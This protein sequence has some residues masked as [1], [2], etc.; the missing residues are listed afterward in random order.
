MFVSIAWSIVYCGAPGG[1]RSA[2]YATI[3]LD[4]QYFKGFC[5]LPVSRHFLVVWWSLQIFT[6]SMSLGPQEAFIDHR[7]SYVGATAFHLT[8][9][10]Q[11]AYRAPCV[12][13]HTLKWFCTL[14]RVSST[15][16]TEDSL[17][18]SMHCSSV[19]V[20]RGLWS[21]S[22]CCWS[23]AR[24]SWPFSGFSPLGLPLEIGWSMQFVDLHMHPPPKNV[25]NQLD[26]TSNDKQ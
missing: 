24:A 22:H 26:M 6:L 15:H 7:K 2:F 12:A 16:P 5:H 23:V 8:K 20:V 3:D 25:I 19:Q 21:S 9:K 11:P 18:H 4:P 13:C 10:D 17:F 1:P 14:S